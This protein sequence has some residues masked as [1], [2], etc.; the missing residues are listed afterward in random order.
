MSI[1]II[2]LLARPH[3]WQLAPKTSHPS[4]QTRGQLTDLRAKAH[5]LSELA[6]GGLTWS[7]GFNAQA[8]GGQAVR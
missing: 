2:R 1:I 4:S 3:Y 5:A 8:A 6:T 7:W